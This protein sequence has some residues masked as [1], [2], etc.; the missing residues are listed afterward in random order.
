MVFPKCAIAEL[1]LDLA[2]AEPAETGSS[3]LNKRL[4][5]WI[6]SGPCPHH[7]PVRLPGNVPLPRLFGNLTP[8]QGDHDLCR[9]EKRIQS[10]SK[11]LVG[12][13]EV[14]AP[15]QQSGSH[16]MV[17]IATKAQSIG[18]RGE[19]LDRACGVPPGEEQIGAGGLCIVVWPFVGV[20]LCAPRAQ[21]KKS[22][23]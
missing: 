6:S 17:P 8:L 19:R 13:A 22:N 7:E 1:G 11:N 5:L 4:N 20:R 12:G 9:G 14:A 23:D 10:L 16:E 3:F 21:L 18:E 2:S 15:F